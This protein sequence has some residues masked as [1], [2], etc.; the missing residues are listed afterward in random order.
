MVTLVIP[1]TIL[2]AAYGA[3]CL[4]HAT[5]GWRQ[6]RLA[7]LLALAATV[8]ML[9]L[10]WPTLRFS[11]NAGLTTQLRR[12]D[13]ALP[14]GPIVVRGYEGL[15]TT[16]ALG[17]GRD[18]LPLR[19]EYVSVNAA[20][21]AFWAACHPCTLLHAS[22]EGLDGLQ[23][24]AARTFQ[25]SREYVAP[26]FRPLA[27]ELRHETLHVLVSK[28]SGIAAEEPP[29]NTGAARD[30][31]V[32]DHGFH[33]DE[34]APGT[35]SRWTAGDAAMTL[36][37]RSADWIEVRLASGAP[38]LLP[39]RVE[40]DGVPRF[41]GTI[42]PGE[43]RWRLSLERAADSTHR[44]TLRSPTFVPTAVGSDRDRRSLG[45]SVRAVRLLDAA[46]APLLAGDSPASDFRS[47][48]TVRRTGLHPLDTKGAAHAFRVDIDNL[49]AAAWP[50]AGE[51]APGAPFVGL[52]Y[53]WTRASDPRRLAEQRIA[54]PYSLMPREH[55]S[56]AMVLDFD[57]DPLRQLP[58]G[59]YDLHVGLVL[60]GVAW[61]GERGDDATTL[62]MTIGA[63]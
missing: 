39:L 28:V 1:M 51:A 16:L 12:V 58:A 44:L 47:R 30:W 5:A 21:R 14:A 33:R 49:G 52:G 32:D 62:R 45:V 42:G 63:R 38:G 50:A 43:T 36:R 41:D 10:Q 6:H 46:V 23:L 8:S 11:E 17:F 55:W 48:I 56:T 15:A 34:L 2:V 37:T 19:D 7:Q 60:E 29:P 9:A 24:D 27:R 4:L 54:L 31:R 57:A 26:T 40:I 35:V 22:Y 61:F 20:S 13:A 3:Q 18:V 53:Y 59:D 25:L